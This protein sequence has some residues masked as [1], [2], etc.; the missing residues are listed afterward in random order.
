[1]AKFMTSK[2]PTSHVRAPVVERVAG[3]SAKHRIAVVVGWLLLVAVAFVVGQRLGVPNTNTYDPG[4]A[5]QAERVLNQP[6]VQQPD[7]ESVLVQARSP[8][9]TLANDPQMR[10]AVTSVV[11][12]L[13]K[14]PDAAA[15]IRSPP[16]A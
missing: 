2:D 12:A 5:G 8:G 1:M 6:D 16:R 15:D 13:G 10:Q 7:H 11:A 3:W 9:R 4:Q 14:L